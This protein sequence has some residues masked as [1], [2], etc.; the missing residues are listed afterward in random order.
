MIRL[1]GGS[2]KK[3]IEV[4]PFNWPNVSGTGSGTR[5]LNHDMGTPYYS[6]EIFRD[7]SSG[8]RL[9]PMDRGVTGSARYG[10]ICYTSEENVQF[11]LYRNIITGGGSGD[12]YIAVLTEL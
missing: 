2:A 8:L 9:V 12:D 10:Y 6:V 11:V 3:R 5:I 7:V 4:G 1:A